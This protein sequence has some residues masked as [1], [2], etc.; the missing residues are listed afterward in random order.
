MGPWTDTGDTGA[1]R[2]L[3]MNIEPD[4]QSQT[5]HSTVFGLQGNILTYVPTATA[6]RVVLVENTGYDGYWSAV[7]DEG[8]TVPS[9]VAKLVDGQFSKFTGV[10]GGVSLDGQ[11]GLFMTYE[12][13]GHAP[14][15]AMYAADGALIGDVLQTESEGTCYGV[16]PTAHGAAFTSI[17]GSTTFHVIEFSAAGGVALDV[18]IPYPRTSLTPTACPNLVLTDD[19]FAYLG[20]VSRADGDGWTIHR[21][22]RDGTISL[23]AW[24]T[25]LG[26][27][28]P[29][30]AVQ[31]DTAIATCIQTNQTT[32]VKHAHGQDQRFP[33]ERTGPPIPSEPGTLFVEMSAPQSVGS[34]GPVAREIFEIRCAD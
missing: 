1:R 19:G 25:L 9:M 24:D 3:W 30:L 32:I 16:F 5:L 27:T 21:V 22:A 6:N 18:R 17:E 15:L 26:C 20:F 23:E 29:A 34:P 12:V 28:A 14:W 31:G 11:R 7:M 4:G 33:L 13:A 10:R 8:G 2:L